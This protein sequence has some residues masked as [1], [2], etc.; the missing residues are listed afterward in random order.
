MINKKRITNDKYKIL[1]NL[2]SKFKAISI[3]IS[4]W[5]SLQYKAEENIQKEIDRIEKRLRLKAYQITQQ[6]SK[7]KDNYLVD[8]SNCKEAYDRKDLA[9]FSLDIVLYPIGELT[10]D[11]Y[12]N[13]TNEFLKILDDSKV[14]NYRKSKKL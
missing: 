12:Q 4:G 10:D 2:P 8:Y 7:L 11:D 3:E 14:F 6:Y 9:Y 5:K 1:I 13:I